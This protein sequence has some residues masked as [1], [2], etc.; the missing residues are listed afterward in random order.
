MR[1]SKEKGKILI[2]D[3]EE[4][5]R[6]ILALILREEGFDVESARDGFDAI[7]KA[8][9]FAPHVLIVDLQMPRMDGVETIK[10]I[11]ESIP[12]TI[13]IILTAHGTIQSAVDAIRQGAYDYLTKPFDN[14][15][16]LAVISRAFQIYRLK[17]EV[18]NL[19]KE[20]RRDYSVKGI[21]GESKIIEDIRR[22]ICQLA[23]TDATILIE[24][25]SGTGKELAARA[26]HYESKRRNDPF[27]I[28]DCTAIPSNLIESEFFGYEKG[29]FTDART[30]Q[31]GKFEEA[32]SGTIFLDE[33]AELSL[34]AQIRL[35]RVLQEKEF[36]RVGGLVPVK[37]DVRIIA[38]TNRNLQKQVS[39]AS[40]RE[41]LFYRLNVLTLQMP[42]LRDHRA[43]IPIYVESLLKK[44][45]DAFGKS[46]NKMSAEVLQTLQQ[47]EW[48]GNFRELENA[49]QRAIFNSTGSS[50]E[51]SD[52]SNFPR[53]RAGD[54]KD[55]STLS[56]DKG[57]D[58][59]IRDLSRDIERRIIMQTLK[60][61]NWNRSEAAR[62][63]KIS[64]KTL[65]NK[66]VQYHL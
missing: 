1:T 39:L 36:T 48:K 17:E 25:E 50:L 59:Y 29:A 44:Y 22:K 28:V 4:K 43:D 18:N 19:R 32:H 8:R 5:I 63:L 34:D 37:V 61:V 65:F 57:L 58:S 21:L 9:S 46:V 41:D 20:L 51:M 24:G 66:I 26:I 35:L 45:A 14:D 23:Q 40:F 31:R 54:L 53:D 6:S 55:W 27:I 7:D 49:I 16:M 2:V 52:L 12:E 62:R 64:R 47:L 13:A 42:S 11:R 38:A 56:A 30:R 10:R 15:Q 60:E 3:D 33:I